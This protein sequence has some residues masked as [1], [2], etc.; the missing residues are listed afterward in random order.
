MNKM[1]FIG[2]NMVMLTDM[3]IGETRFYK[4]PDW[5]DEYSFRID[6]NKYTIKVENRRKKPA[7]EGQSRSVS[8]DDCPVTNVCS[9]KPIDHNQ[10]LRQDY[11][12]CPAS[13]AS[14]N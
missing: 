14:L 7:P 8:L 11:D 10:V 13:N 5:V 6:G 3:L 1:E 2:R 4:I 12:Y 9:N